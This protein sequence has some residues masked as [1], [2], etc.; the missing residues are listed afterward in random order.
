MIKVMQRDESGTIADHPRGNPIAARRIL[1]DSTSAGARLITG[2]GHNFTGHGYEPKFI[3]VPVRGHT[4]RQSL[5]VSG[6]RSVKVISAHAHCGFIPPSQFAT[7]GV[8]GELQ[9]RTASFT[10]P[11]HRVNRTHS[12]SSVLTFPTNF[13][14]TSTTQ[15]KNIFANERR[16]DS[17]GCMR[18]QNPVKYAE[19]LLSMV[20]LTK[21]AS[22]TLL[23]AILV[24]AATNSGLR[25]P[26]Q[27]PDD[28]PGQ[29]KNIFAN[30]RRA[31]SHGCMRV[32][33][34]VKYA[35]V[36][37][38]MVQLTK[39][40]STT[41]LAAILV[42]AATNS[43]LRCP[44]QGPDDAPGL[45]RCGTHYSLAESAAGVTASPTLNSA[46]LC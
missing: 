24:A 38:S 3:L 4:L 16:A 11:S 44:D 6:H 19:V 37:L 18:V 14:C 10:C 25:C 21:R 33:N 15:I 12:G 26:D 32:Q 13:W 34:P 46:G 35:E 1:S 40:A 41:L 23:A 5:S 8:A 2:D 9:T 22:T 30:E 28:A 20:Q 39:R 27:G 42:A 17:H 45:L 7:D 29:I 36:L 43:G 31:D